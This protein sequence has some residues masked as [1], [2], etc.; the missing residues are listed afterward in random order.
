MAFLF[1]LLNM[2]IRDILVA[3]IISV[4][5]TVTKISLVLQR[6][7]VLRTGALGNMSGFAA[8]RSVVFSTILCR[9]Y[10]DIC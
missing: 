5:V 10:Y 2:P 8:V 6:T 4:L 7:G 1:E 9:V 3:K